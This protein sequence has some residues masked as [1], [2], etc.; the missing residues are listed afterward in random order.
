LSIKIL[1]LVIKENP[2]D[3]ITTGEKG[4]GIAGTD[5]KVY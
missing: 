4:G 1:Y 5:K 2:E 3:F